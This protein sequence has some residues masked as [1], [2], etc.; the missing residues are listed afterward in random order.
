MKQSSYALKHFFDLTLAALL[1]VVLAPLLLLLALLIRLDSPGPI[2]FK[3]PRLGRG[4]RVFEI[5]KF[6][7]MVDGAEKVG[8][9]IF[10]SRS[11]PRITRIGQILRR[12][13][14]DELPQLIN[15]LRGEMSFVGPRP[16]VPYHPH[17]FEDY[18]AEQRRRFDVLP[19][20]TGYAQVVGR[21]RLTWPERIRY[22]LE[23]IDAW[24]LS[25]D[26][27]I[28]LQTFQVVGN[29]QTVFSDRNAP[30]ASA[31]TPAQTFV[32]PQDP[33]EDPP[34]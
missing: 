16:P 30:Q 10:T 21:N 26:A 1:L 2:F 5:Y 18:S 12:T 20:I 7:T 11:D 19:G 31:Q 3:Q 33:P 8:S 25:F 17:R 14:L 28:V 24:S 23:Y 32:A 15:V 29:R 34:S 9:G 13:S 22:D 4:G 27:R 6:R